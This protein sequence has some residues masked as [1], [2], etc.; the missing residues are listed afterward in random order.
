MQREREDWRNL[1]REFSKF[2]REMAGEDKILDE[3]DTKIVQFVNENLK[4]DFN[5]KDIDEIDHIVTMY[6]YYQ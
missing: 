4:M 6:D 3:Q 5:E 2:I 1:L